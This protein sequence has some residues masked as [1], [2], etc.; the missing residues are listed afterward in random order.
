VIDGEYYSMD[1]VKDPYTGEYGFWD[2]I[3]YDVRNKLVEELGENSTK[4]NSELVEKLLEFKPDEDFLK[5][6]K[7]SIYNTILRTYYGISTDS[8]PTQVE[9]LPIIYLGAIMKISSDDLIT[10]NWLPDKYK[11]KLDYI[12]DLIDDEEL[13]KKYKECGRSNTM[14]KALLRFAFGFNYK[15]FNEDIYK[16][17]LYLKIFS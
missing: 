12:L 1:Y 17:I 11:T 16:R 7:N 8:K 14:M 3:I 4:V 5:N 13:N 2:D 6:I 10:T 9:M 15:V